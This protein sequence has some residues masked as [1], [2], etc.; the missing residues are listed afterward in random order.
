[1]NRKELIYVENISPTSSEQNLQ[2]YLEKFAPVQAV[3]FLR[4]KQCTKRSIAAFLRV[5]NETDRDI[6]MLRNQ[7]NYRGKRLFMLQ[8]D[9]PHDYQADH[10][11]IVRN[12]TTKISEENLFEHFED[13]GK[14]AFLQIRTDDFAYVAFEDKTSVRNAVNKNN[15]PL[16]GSNLKIQLLT[17][18]LDIMIVNLDTLCSRMPD[19]YRKLVLPLEPRASNGQQQ[20]PVGQTQPTAVEQQSKSQPTQQQQ[21]SQKSRQQQEQQQREN[22]QRE[23]QQRENQQ[24]Q[25][26]IQRENQQRQQQLQR[27]NQQRQQQQRENQQRQQQQQAQQQ[28]L[29]QQQQL[30][31]QQKP[32]PQRQQNQRQLQNQQQQLQQ[33]IQMLKDKANALAEKQQQQKQAPAQQPPKSEPVVIE[34]EPPKKQNETETNL[35]TSDTDDVQIVEVMETQEIIEDDD[36]DTDVQIVEK[37]LVDPIPSEYQRKPDDVMRPLKASEVVMKDVLNLKGEDDRRAVWVNNIQPETRRLDL[38]MYLEQ[39]GDVM[40]CKVGNSKN[41]AFTRW[42]KVLFSSEDAAARAAEYFV[43]PFQGRYL[44]VLHC[45]KFVVEEP[46]KVFAIDFLSKYLVYED[47]AKA[48]KHIGEVFYMVRLYDNNYKVR[49]FFVNAVDE[50]KVLAVGSIGSHPIKL[51]LYVENMQLRLQKT[52]A[53]ELRAAREIMDAAMEARKAKI[54]AIYKQEALDR[55]DPREYT[56]PDPKTSPFEVIIYNVPVGTTD[57]QIKR[58]FK[59]IGEPTAIRRETMHT[60]THEVREVE[61][62]YVGFSRLSM[63]MQAAEIPP[64]KKLNSFNPF[65]FLATTQAAMNDGNTLR[66]FFNNFITIQDIYNGLIHCGPIKYIEK[67]RAKRALIMFGNGET[68]ITDAKKMNFIGNVKIT[69]KERAN[70]TA[71]KTTDLSGECGNITTSSNPSSME[72]TT[73]NLILGTWKMSRLPKLIEKAD[74]KMI[75]KFLNKHNVAVACLQDAQMNGRRADTR[76]YT[77]HGVPK[78]SGTVML[79]HNNLKKNCVLQRNQQNTCLLEINLF[80]QS[81]FICSVC[82]GGVGPNNKPSPSLIKFKSFIEGMQPEK[83]ACMI[84]LGHFNANIGFED[85]ADIQNLIGE[86]LLHPTS[87]LNGTVLKQMLKETNMKLISSYGPFLSVQCTGKAFGE[88]IQV[89][90]VIMPDINWLVKPKCRTICDEMFDVD[91][92]ILLLE[93]GFIASNLPTPKPKTETE[94]SSATTRAPQAKKDCFS[95]AKHVIFATWNVSGCFRKVDRNDVDQYLHQ[96]HVDVACVQE[97]HMESRSLRTMSY[98]WYNV[99]KPTVKQNTSEL[100]SGTAILVRMK[101]AKQ[102]KFDRISDNICR[103]TMPIAGKEL[104]VYSVYARTEGTFSQPDKEI[105]HLHNMIKNMPESKRANIIVLGNM[106]AHIGYR[107]MAPGL[108]GLVGDYLCHDYSNANGEQILQTLETYKLKL[109]SSFG[110]CPSVKYTSKHGDDEEQLAH[111]I[112]PSMGIF[113]QTSCMCIDSF[114]DGFSND[115]ILLMR[116]SIKLGETSGF[117]NNGE[118][119]ESESDSETPPSKVNPQYTSEDNANPATDECAQDPQ[120]PTN[121]RPHTIGTWNVMG[122]ATERVDRFL[123]SQEVD[124]AC[125]QETQI[126]TNTFRTEHYIWFNVHKIGAS[127]GTKGGTAIAVCND[128]AEQC[129]FKQWSDN[130]CWVKVPIY[131]KLVIVISVYA[132]TAGVDGLLPDPEF[133]SLS[134]ILSGLGARSRANLIIMGDFQA[135]I[136]FQDMPSR[137]QSFIG[138]HLYHPFSNANGEGLKLILQEFDL[139]LCSSFGPCESVTCT[140]QKGDQQAQTSHIIMPIIDRFLRPK[141]RCVDCDPRLSEHRMLLLTVR[142]RILNDNSVKKAP[143]AKKR[144]A[145]GTFQATRFGMNDHRKQN[146]A[147]KNQPAIVIDDEDDVVVVPSNES[148]NKKNQKGKNQPKGGPTKKQPQKQH[149]QNKQHPQQGSGGNRNR[150]SNQ[151][152]GDGQQQFHMDQQR[153]PDN[154]PWQNNQQDPVWQD[155]FNQRQ[156][157]QNQ[158]MPND[159]FNPNGPFDRFGN[160]EPNMN[161]NMN[162]FEQMM[163]AQQFDNFNFGN[164]D[165]NF[166]RGNPMDT[167]DPPLERN[168]GQQQHHMQQQ[169]H[170]NRFSPPR[171]QSQFNRGFSDERDDFGRDSPGIPPN[172]P[173]DEIDNYI[174]QK[175]EAIKRRLEQLD[176]QL[177]DSV[178]TSRHRDFENSTRRRQGTVFSDNGDVHY[179]PNPAAVARN[180]GGRRGGRGGRGDPG[181][182]NNQE[183]NRN[184]GRGRRDRE[185]NF[186]NR[187]RDPFADVDIVPIIRISED[188]SPSPK[189]SREDEFDTAQ[190]DAAWI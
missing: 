167:D 173:E 102:C 132:H 177:I 112:M 46:G 74:Y 69:V 107:D 15:Q 72:N 23:N 86:Q 116:A 90:H 148:P 59:S 110:P 162:Q 81:L 78:K 38:V 50:Q 80:G 16:K 93:T 161:M 155:Q 134:T 62:V 135:Q 64:E 147:G 129:K 114:S 182:N 9:R 184:R 75:D 124:V 174:V 140:W 157:N 71:Q 123:H 54:N 6:I 151:S 115:R 4:E 76:S 95:D 84:I 144:T 88:R 108:R 1:M 106:N 8:A 19:L 56:N 99:N 121:L 44:F 3:Y 159:R 91:R 165:N 127:I 179:V 43:H 21:Q 137:L 141:C 92:P 27:E 169:Q 53:N 101:Y 60:E 105:M 55:C 67:Q 83:R 58:Y 57:Q 30:L 45:T 29:Q 25:Q 133:K 51:E 63:A 28:R 73:E 158:F 142:H 139:R 171:H 10:T 145:S 136:G 146:D 168:W 113:D 35:N 189:R 68:G 119:A 85:S 190:F 181:A 176:R 125:L 79:I 149:Q 180:R 40:H 186:R 170:F 24:R 18:N 13:C 97:T 89:D 131:G 17:R 31:Q 98:L 185:E 22:Q 42:A 14:I 120:E 37:P 187:T 117:C 100:E 103:M 172:I 175:Q 96:H 188:G 153:F 41:C 94:I 122:G 11:V 183:A 61:S 65:I 143:V 2:V 70:I 150:R 154:N 33:Q 5:A 66:L 118:F 156:R 52:V 166:N 26:Q 138:N 160:Q 36:D 152:F 34:E 126:P 47:V 12:I 7:Q 128:L 111:I 130:I 39:F 32:L 104:Y 178:E 163:M 164:N 109:V 20:Q 77:W 48:F 82:I 87:D 49:I